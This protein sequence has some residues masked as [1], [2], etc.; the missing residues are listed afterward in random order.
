MVTEKAVPGVHATTTEAVAFAALPIRPLMLPNA[1]GV[2]VTVQADRTVSV[3]AMVPVAV[4][5]TTGLTPPMASAAT[6]KK[7]VADFHITQPRNRSTKLHLQH[8]G[9]FTRAALSVT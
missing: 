9:I 7:V 5:A 3:T 1:S 6:L 4:A 8:F 2:G